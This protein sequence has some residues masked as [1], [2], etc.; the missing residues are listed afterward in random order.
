LTHNAPNDYQIKALVEGHVRNSPSITFNG[1][2]S[3][4]MSMSFHNKCET[5]SF[6]LRASH[7]LLSYDLSDII[8]VGTN[9]NIQPAGTL[10]QFNKLSIVRTKMITKS[11]AIGCLVL[12]GLN[13]IKKTEPFFLGE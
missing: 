6:I 9:L 2:S 10:F 7:Y 4:P 8:F 5:H 12:F 3:Y 1:F 11:I 13:P